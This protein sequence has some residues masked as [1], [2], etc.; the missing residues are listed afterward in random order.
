MCSDHFSKWTEIRPLKKATEAETARVLE[1]II[2][3]HR[4]MKHL[5]SDRGANFMAQIITE[6]YKVME[7]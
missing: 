3:Q 7:I 5:I 1:E 6:L 4:V 2:C